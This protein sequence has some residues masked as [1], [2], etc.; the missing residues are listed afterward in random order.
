[1]S[2]DIRTDL[3]AQAASIL[4]S[5][6]WDGFM[7]RWVEE[8]VEEDEYTVHTADDG[9]TYYLPVHDDVTDDDAM[10]TEEVFREECEDSPADM[11]LTDHAMEV[12]A[13]GRRS[14]HDDDWEV[15]GYEVLRTFGGPNIWIDFDPARVARDGGPVVIRAYWGSD[16]IT[17]HGWEELGVTD[18][19]DAMHSY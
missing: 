3:E 17:V 18:E 19:L 1:M 4:E 15:T 2:N 6:S 13:T 11:W 10:T 7:S 5:L 16:E 12:V 14:G 8:N 9:S